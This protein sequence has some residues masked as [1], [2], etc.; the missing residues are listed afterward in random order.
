[1]LDQELEVSFR[2]KRSAYVVDPLLALYSPYGAQLVSRL[3][4]LADLTVTRTFW[5]AI[6]AS[7]YYRKD[8]LGF[9]PSAL[10]ER[11]PASTADDFNQALTLWEDE[12]LRTD[13]SH[14]RLHWV[15]DNVSE[16]SF[17]DGTRADLIERYEA[18]HQTLTARSDPGD[19]ATESAAFYGTIDSLAL[20]AALGNA[21]VLTLAPDQPQAC[22]PLVCEHVG[23]TLEQPPT[24]DAELIALEQRR[25]RQLVVAAG[26]SSLLWGGLRLAVVHPLLYG[27]LLRVDASELEPGERIAFEHRFDYIE[28]P[29]VAVTTGDPWRAARHF[30]H[31]I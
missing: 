16:S 5:Q 27:D 17:P 23:L 22:L 25:L 21:C 8:P 20:A 2:A 7:D 28:P 12:R 31:A 6:D 10:R 19:D 1:M 15:I 13:L 24:A 11:L 14:C 9:W 29:P 18:L 30:W 4:A 26:C 3:S